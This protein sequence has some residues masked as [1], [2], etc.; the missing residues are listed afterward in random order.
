MVAEGSTLGFVK[1]VRSRTVSDQSTGPTDGGGDD[2]GKSSI[3]VTKAAARLRG[4][5]H[6]GG[7]AP[8]DDTGMDEHGDADDFEFGLNPDRRST[9][10]G[11]NP[12]ATAAPSASA[13]AEARS[14]RAASTSTYSL[15]GFKRRSDRAV[16]APTR[17]TS[18]SPTARSSRNSSSA[19][20]GAESSDRRG[21]F[22]GLGLGLKKVSTF[23]FANSVGLAVKKAREQVRQQRA[24]SDARSFARKLKIMFTFSQLVSNLSFVLDINFPI[25]A[26]E[27]MDWLTWVSG[28]GGEGTG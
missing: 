27:L 3:A 22:G 13:S 26:Q 9:V 5:R 14:G 1:K 15:F 18:A 11:S 10:L 6:G 17:P 19:S 7:G 12:A 28:V 4:L 24:V 20:G 16:S 23:L 8:P 21:S 2:D 25:Q